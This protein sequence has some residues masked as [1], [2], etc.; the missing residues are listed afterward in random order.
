MAN[1]VGGVSSFNFANDPDMSKR[2][3]ARD[4]FDR[5]KGLGCL[6]DEYSV[7]FCLFCPDDQKLVDVENILRDFPYEKIDP[8]SKTE[9]Y[10]IN[11]DKNS[12]RVDFAKKI[13]LRLS[14]KGYRIERT[15]P[16]LVVKYPIFLSPGVAKEILKG[17]PYSYSAPMA[18]DY[19]VSPSTGGSGSSGAA[20]PS[21][22]PAALR[23]DRKND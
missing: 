13:I 10:N 1:T 19:N 6:F 3:K 22:A 18:L 14:D 15:S 12:A 16:S 11:D 2:Q 8:I 5:L 23:P 20:T 17:Y 4:I 21:Y 7:P 9:Y